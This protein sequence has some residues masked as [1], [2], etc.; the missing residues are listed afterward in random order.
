MAPFYMG[1]KTFI[2][3]ESVGRADKV[4]SVTTVRGVSTK[5]EAAEHVARDKGFREPLSPS[6]SSVYTSTFD[7]QVR[8]LT[9]K[10]KDNHGRH[11]D[12]D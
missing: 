7:N 8:I 2:V 10:V 3:K 4:C 6:S 1:T 9:V 11:D 5:K 12:N